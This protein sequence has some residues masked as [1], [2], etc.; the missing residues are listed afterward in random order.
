MNHPNTFL[1]QRKA[2]ARFRRAIPFLASIPPPIYNR[3]S[4]LS[5]YEPFGEIEQARLELEEQLDSYVMLYKRYGPEP[6][7][8][9]QLFVYIYE[10]S[11]TPKQQAV[12]N[13]A[14]DLLRRLRIEAVAYQKPL[15]IRSEPLEHPFAHC[16]LPDAD[17]YQG[18]AGHDPEDE[19]SF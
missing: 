5:W 4:P 13:E 14:N 12:L 9:T 1:I 16:S 3:L 15:R 10:I 8:E 17:E 7:W 2:L 11:L 6:P 18:L 19:I